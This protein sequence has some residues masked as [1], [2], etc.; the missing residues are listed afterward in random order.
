MEIN[1]DRVLAYHLAKVIDPEETTAIAGGA[2][3]NGATTNFWPT[4][5]ITGLCDPDV[6]L[7]HN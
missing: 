4:V 6:C 1:K 7:D 2:H 3:G 5:T